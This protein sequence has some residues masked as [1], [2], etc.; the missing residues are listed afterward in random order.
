[1]PVMT[2]TADLGRGSYGL[3]LGSI[4]RSE[5]SGAFMTKAP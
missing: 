2:L 5:G 3:A 4:A 1:M